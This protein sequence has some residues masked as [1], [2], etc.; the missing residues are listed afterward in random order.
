MWDQKGLASTEHDCESD[1]MSFASQDCSLNADNKVFRERIYVLKAQ[2]YNKYEV[3][4]NG[5]N[6]QQKQF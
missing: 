2:I 4:C 1:L 5:L 6:V 3:S